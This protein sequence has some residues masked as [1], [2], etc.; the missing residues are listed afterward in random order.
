MKI[1]LLKEVYER[2]PKLLQGGKLLELVRVYEDL[3]KTIRFLR[4]KQANGAHLSASLESIDVKKLL[5]QLARSKK[6][7]ERKI[8]NTILLEKQHLKRRIRAIAANLSDR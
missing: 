7:I 3:E 5:A 6:K 2:S 4:K 1:P 8:S